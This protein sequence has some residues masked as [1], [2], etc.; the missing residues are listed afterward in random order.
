M[1]DKYVKYKN[2]KNRIY[3]IGL[4]SRQWEIIIDAIAEALGL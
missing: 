3:A 1:Y 2:F 4:S